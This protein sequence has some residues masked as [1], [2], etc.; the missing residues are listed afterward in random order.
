MTTDWI[1]IRVLGPLRVRSAD[2]DLIRDK[3]WRTGKNADLLR[4]LA[5]EGGRPVAVEA[6]IE[7]LWP[8]VD[9]SRA[10]ASLRTAVSHLRRVLGAEVIERSGSDVVLRSAWVDATT[11]RGIAE[12]VTHRRRE[13]DPAAVLAAAREADSLYLTDV[14]TTEASPAAIRQHSEDLAAAHRRLLGQ[15]AELALELGWMRDAVDYAARLLQLDPVSELA[16]RVLMLGHSGMGEVHHALREY[17]R[18]RRVLADELGVD[19][20]PQTRAVH[21]QVLQAGGGAPTRGPAPFVGRHAELE[22]LASMLADVAGTGPRIAVLAGRTGSG[23]RRLATVACQDAGLRPVR[24]ETAADLQVAVESGA[25]VLLWRPDTAAELPL[26]SR[27]LADPAAVVGSCT[28]LLAT[29]APGEDPAWDALVSAHG[30]R[31]MTVPPLLVDEVEQLARHLLAGPVTAG[32]VE[33]LVA[34]SDALPG[35]VEATVQ[36]WARAGRLVGTDAGLALAPEADA[37]GDDPW[38]RRVLAGALPRLE[39]DA[40]EAL[41]IAAVIDEPLTPSVLAPVLP[42]GPGLPRVRAT[43]ALEQLVD[44]SVLQASP[45]GAVWRHPRLQDAARAWMRPSVRRRLHRRVAEQAPIPTAH[46][47]GHWLQAGERELACVAALQAAEEASAR[48]NHAGARTHLLQVCSLGDLREAATADRIELFEQLGDACAMLRLTDEA[49]EAYTTALDIALADAVPDAARLR[50]KLTGV[51]D[52]RTLEQTADAV[53]PEWSRALSGLASAAAAT[54]PER[55]LEDTLLDAVAQADRT[56]DRRAGFHARVRLAGSVYLHRREFRAVHETLEAAVALGPRPADRLRADL[57]R[58]VPSVL[59]GGARTAHSALEA[60]GRV[61][62]DLGD[63]RLGWR[64]LGMRAVVAH[65]L[66]DPGFDALWRVLR[67]RV[68]RGAVDDLIPELAALG[69]RICVEREELD[70]AQAMSQ[71]L[72]FAGGPASVLVDQLARLAG[73]ELAGAMGDHRH[74]TE[75]LRSVVEDGPAAGC[76]LL[77]PEA[78]ARLVVLEASNN[79]ASARAAFEVYDDI[80]GAALGGPR[81]EFWRRMARAAVRAARGDHEGAAD[82]CAQASSLAHQHGLQVLAARARRERAEHVR[83]DLPRTLAMVRT[84]PREESA[85]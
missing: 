32:L 44:L 82:A 33:S 34:A 53:T 52:P 11:F 22:W 48:G 85:G 20:S 70:L 45:A 38:G 47:I 39:G 6:L 14:P 76:T 51:S 12:H 61:A 68:L 13:G 9:E 8:E 77:V 16:S 58:Y 31:T 17:E 49:R 36:S 7:G 4:W 69:L 56:H 80:V 3:D 83:V 55:S 75:Q 46:R 71:H 2:G 64:L 78:A 66:G 60:A 15:A 74:A 25:R 5:L 57:V 40:L 29:P 65:D 30:V 43:T 41:H 26:L 84:G 63:E 27:L 73:S 37:A 24:V 50:R 54:G 28:V 72:P 67:D 1:E 35:E 79:P 10:R 59:L 23:R 18:C 62:A 42:D 19:P 81:E 21:L